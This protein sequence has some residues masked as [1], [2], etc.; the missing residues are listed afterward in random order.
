MTHD[1]RLAIIPVPEDTDD[2]EQHLRIREDGV[3]K[4]RVDSEADPIITSLVV[5][6]HGGVSPFFAAVLIT[7]SN[8]TSKYPSDCSLCHF[9]GIRLKSP[10]DIVV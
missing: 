8:G 7:D 1:T 6:P 5:R 4:V 10:T 3:D 2:S 9:N